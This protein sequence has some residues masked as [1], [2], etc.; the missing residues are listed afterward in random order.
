MSSS[1]MVKRVVHIDRSAVAKDGR[2]TAFVV[3]GD[4]RGRV[5]F[6]SGKARASSAAIRHAF[7]VAKKNTIVVALCGGTIPFAAVG[8]HGAGKV[9]LKPAFDGAGIMGAGAIKVIMESVGIRN[10]LTKSVGSENPGTVLNATFEALK[11]LSA[12]V[13]AVFPDEIPSAVSSSEQ[14]RRMIA[15]M[16]APTP[17]PLPQ[18][19]L[20]ARRNAV[21]RDTMLRE[22]G[23]LTGADI[24]EF[25]GSKSRNRTALAQRWKSDGRI[26]CVLY[27]G[28]S[29][30]PG[31]QFSKECQPL[32][33]IA[34][35]VKILGEVL[36][37]W[38]LAIWFCKNNGALGGARA[39]DLLTSAPLRVI[40]AAKE[41]A[42]ELVF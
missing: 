6:G 40:D 4:G 16:V 24:A 3:I 31:F 27:Q 37:P 18:H 36:S 38:E 17:I 2:V 28:L 9:L 12:D 21:A 19:V 1:G 42:E 30:F 33:V 10:I 22:F 11:N 20:Q 39:V 7:E 8:Y 26:F 25:A 14:I 13:A 5:G 15:A 23:A 35:V 29:Y 41:E 34:D 32:P